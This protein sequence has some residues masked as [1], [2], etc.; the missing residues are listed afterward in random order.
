MMVFSFFNKTEG[1]GTVS[2][3]LRNISETSG[4]SYNTLANW[5]RDGKTQHVNE[6][7]IIFKTEVKRGNQRV[8]LNDE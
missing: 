7:I 5:F 2:T 3:S 8:K 1:E 4:I 6:D